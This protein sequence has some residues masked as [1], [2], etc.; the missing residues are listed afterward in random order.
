MAQR[1]GA[2][3]SPRR[4]AA[5]D[6]VER[7]TSRE[8]SRTVRSGRCRRGTEWDDFARRRAQKCEI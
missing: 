3:R 7:V 1:P 4:Y 8:L 2:S 6:G 5:P